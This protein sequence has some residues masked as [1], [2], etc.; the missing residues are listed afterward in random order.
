MRTL[1]FE[2]GV[3]PAREM[4][5]EIDPGVGPDDSGRATPSP[6]RHG[7]RAPR[8]RRRW[9]RWSAVLAAVLA[10]GGAGGAVLARPRGAPR[11]T[12]AS[13]A[14]PKGAGAAKVHVIDMHRAVPKLCRGPVAPGNGH[15]QV[16][17]SQMFNV[18]DDVAAPY[19][20]GW[21]L[22]PYHGA[23][24]YRLGTGGN[25]MALEPPSS[26]APL[27]FATGTLIVGANGTSGVVDASVKLATGAVVRVS[28]PWSCGS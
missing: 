18:T 11:A 1:T 24:A 25:L 6:A 26:G 22:V 17:L 10:I 12:H 15:P 8:N 23:G 9:L 16:V 5:R 14:L 2:D 3:E 21:Q 4:G 19:L 7:E 27:G 13:H 28:G 20:L